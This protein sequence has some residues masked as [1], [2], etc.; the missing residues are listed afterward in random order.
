MTQ[1]ASRM[2]FAPGGSVYL[3]VSGPPGTI[4][5]TGGEPELDPREPSTGHG[6]V[7]RLRDDGTVPPDNPF[8]GKPGALRNFTRWAIEIILASHHTRPLARCSTSSSAHTAATRSTFSELV[9]TTVGPI[10]VTDGTTTVRQLRIPTSRELSP[11]YW[12][13]CLASR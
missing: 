7:I 2:A 6:K 3:T 1:G 10:T 9:R 11:P 13:G 8:V 4:A 12:S 5:A